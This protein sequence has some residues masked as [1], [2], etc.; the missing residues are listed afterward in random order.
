MLEDE[1]VVHVVMPTLAATFSL[2]AFALPAFSSTD[3]NHLLL[4]SGSKAFCERSFMI[5][6]YFS[7]ESGP[8]PPGLRTLSTSARSHLKR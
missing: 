4:V 5:I 8:Y 6:P 7:G 1:M 2:R 3:Y